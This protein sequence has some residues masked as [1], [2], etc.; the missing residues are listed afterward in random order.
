MV[1]EIFVSLQS[2]LMYISTNNAGM[3]ENDGI[4]ILYVLIRLKVLTILVTYELV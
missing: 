4:Y 2:D 3:I 1:F